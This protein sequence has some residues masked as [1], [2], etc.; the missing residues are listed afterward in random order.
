MM[1]WIT[2]EEGHEKNLPNESIVIARRK[3]GEETMVYFHEDKMARL[4]WYWKDHKLSYWQRF[5]NGKW[6]YDV[7]HWK[8]SK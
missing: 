7:T 3:C 5:D 4:A 1:Q 6:L 2:V 8:H